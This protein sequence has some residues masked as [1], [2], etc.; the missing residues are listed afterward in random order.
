MKEKTLSAVLAFWFD[1]LEPKHWFVKDSRVDEAIRARFG[2]LYEAMS[3]SGSNH[4]EQ[5]L[6]T[7]ARIIVLDQF[8]R[9]M[10]RETK[11]AFSTDELALQIAGSGIAVG[12]D[13]GLLPSQQAFFYMPYMHSEEAQDQARSV[14]LFAAPG[15]EGNYD[16]AIKHKAIIDR[17]GR[18][19][20]R[21]AV[22]GRKSTEE[23]LHF[24][25]KP[26]S[27]F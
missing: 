10:F 18:Y 2:A 11:Q 20:H 24:M 22:L 9:N 7:L 16:F 13:K 1:E 14:A 3:A 15:L 26:G 19:P 12:Q 25:Q 17:F 21:N 4:S 8:P 5:S 23:E 27:A 6:E